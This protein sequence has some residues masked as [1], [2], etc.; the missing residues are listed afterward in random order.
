MD[1]AAERV[2]GLVREA[3]TEHICNRSEREERQNAK[4]KGPQPRGF[5][6]KWGGDCVARQSK[7]HKGYSP[8]SRLVGA[9]FWAKRRYP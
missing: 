9:P 4:A 5:R 7:I 1:I 6:R 8:S 3:T 2:F